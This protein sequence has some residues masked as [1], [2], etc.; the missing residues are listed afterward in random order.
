MAKAARPRT[1][2]VTCDPIFTTR[3]Q[4][5]ELYRIMAEPVAYWESAA[6][7]ILAEYENSLRTRDSLAHAHVRDDVSSI[8]AA[9]ERAEAGAVEVRLTIGQRLLRW[10]RKFNLWH[11]GKFLGV[12]RSAS[13]VNLETLIGPEGAAA[14]VETWL[15]RN[16]D[17]V[18]SVSDDTRRAIAD[19]VWRGFQGRTPRKDLAKEIA[20]A[21]GLQRKRAQRIASDQTTK[22]A[23]MLDEERQRDAGITHFKCRHSGKVH[24]RPHHLER[25]G[26][27][28]AW[29][30]NDLDGDLPGVAINCGCKAQA[31]I[32]LI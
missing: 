16:V 2:A 25:D 3:A 17:L 6:A 12:V 29:D 19:I 27:I 15:A 23:A 4:E 10:A 8:R 32:D 14:T 1:R 26:K 28:F 22:L 9:I 5:L 18:R 21:T 11:L 24:Y 31:Y 7:G 30:D 20:Q 13:G